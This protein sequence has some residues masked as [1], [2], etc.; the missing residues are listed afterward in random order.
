MNPDS[1]SFHQEEE[2]F[3]SNSQIEQLIREYG[4]D[5]QENH[6]HHHQEEEFDDV[7]LQLENVSSSSS[8]NILPHSQIEDRNSS[9]ESGICDENS[10]DQVVKNENE[11]GGGEEEEEEEEKLFETKHLPLQV[12]TLVLKIQ[13]ELS[14]II[15]ERQ[16][17]HQLREQNLKIFYAA[18]SLL[19]ALK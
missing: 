5:Q 6:H 17:F 3:Y 12:G 15:D 11:D 18:C 8:K 14:E 4:I 2:T 16:D 19:A 10:Q 7:P 9:L 13:N 1:S